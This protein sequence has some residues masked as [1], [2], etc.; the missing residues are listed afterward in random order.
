MDASLEQALGTA[1]CEH[2]G[3]DTYEAALACPSCGGAWEPCV[4]S[5]YPTRAAERLVL[6]RSNMS[7]RRADWNAWVGRFKSDPITGASAA[8]MF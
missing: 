2:C 8:P 6:P 5:G 7:A 1:P 3:A 4:V